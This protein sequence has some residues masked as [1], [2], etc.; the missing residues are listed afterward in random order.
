MP[1]PLIAAAASS[2]FNAI[3]QISQNEKNREFQL[4][5]L[6]RQNMMQKELNSNS[7]LIQRQSL[8]RAGLNANALAGQSPAYGSAAPLGD[9]SS[10]PAPQFDTSA[11]ASLLSVIQQ[12]PLIDAQKRKLDADAHKQEIEN[13]REVSADS[14]YYNADVIANWLDD[15]SGELP[16][17][18]YTPFNKGSFDARRSIRI[19]QSELK[20]LD[21]QD[22]RNALDSLVYNDQLNSS[23]VVKALADMPYKQYRE[24]SEKV[25]NLIKERS[26]MESVIDLN[27]ANADV[28][29]SEKALKDLEKQI[30][31]DSSIFPLIEKYLPEGGLRDFAK[32]FVILASSFGNMPLNLSP[33]KTN[34]NITNN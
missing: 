32:L 31:E 2:M 5:M 23:R 18:K 12:S 11:L 24:L 22:V 3:S 17:L 15:D 8:E 33:R 7:A 25:T 14:E 27:E 34:V 20:S 29:K 1:W 6:D 10:Q 26:V 19:Y 9:A 21:T 13:L 4:E 16:E 30:R 28:A